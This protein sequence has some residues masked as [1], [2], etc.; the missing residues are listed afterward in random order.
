M[1]M[2]Q[3]MIKYQLLYVDKN[4]IFFSAQI[5]RYQTFK[6]LLILGN[7]PNV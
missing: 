7:L 1:Q 2:S 6:M 5:F 4:P 3:Q